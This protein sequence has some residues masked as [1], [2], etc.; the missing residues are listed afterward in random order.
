LQISAGHVAFGDDIG[1]GKTSAGL[2]FGEGF[3]KHAILVER[4]GSYFDNGRNMV[5]LSM[6]GPTQPPWRALSSRRTPD[7]RGRRQPW[8]KAVMEDAMR[9]TLQ[10]E[11]NTE[12]GFTL[13]PGAA[14][15][16]HR[17]LGIYRSG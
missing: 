3:A 11:M 14:T 8:P 13:H 7:R 15:G 10:S 16:H 5:R 4:G 9:D 12:Q 2:E 17:H 6:A 1:H